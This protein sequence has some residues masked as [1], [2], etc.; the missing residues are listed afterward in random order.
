MGAATWT[1][2]CQRPANHLLDA[3]DLEPEWSVKGS[4]SRS[5]TRVPGRNP[6]DVA[7]SASLRILIGD[8]TND[9]RLPGG[10]VQQPLLQD[11]ADRAVQTRDRVPMGIEDGVPEDRG[12]ARLQRLRDVMLEPFGLVIRL[13]PARGRRLDQGSRFQRSR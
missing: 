13:V 10:K 9:C 5:F 3:G 6:R 11:R 8:A 1:I 4:V 7:D 12:H 2:R